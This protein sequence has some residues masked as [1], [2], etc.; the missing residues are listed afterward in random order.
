MHVPSAALGLDD[1]RVTGLREKPTQTVQINRGQYVV[2]PEALDHVPLDQYT[3]MPTVVN[4]VALRA[5]AC[6]LMAPARVHWI[7]TAR[8]SRIFDP[9]QRRRVRR[10]FSMSDHDTVRGLGLDRGSASRGAAYRIWA[11]RRPRD[12]A[13]QRAIGRTSARLS[14]LTSGRAVANETADHGKG[15]HTLA[16]AGLRGVRG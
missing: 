3:D 15:S 13:G 16:R 1:H 2:S 9:R 4:R 6:A 8:M 7:D 12:P 10:R 5:G 11:T 14:R